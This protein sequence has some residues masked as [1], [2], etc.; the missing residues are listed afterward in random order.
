MKRVFY[1]LFCFILLCSCKTE[2]IGSDVPPNLR[3]VMKDGDILYF[4]DS[5][6][7]LVDTFVL[8]ISSYYTIYDNN[9]TIQIKYINKGDSARSI[10]S[11]QSAYGI[12]F[13]VN[14]FGIDGCRVDNPTNVVKNV[15]IN[16]VL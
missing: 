10:D 16:N 4:K 14:R 11:Y 7:N 5:V 3:P 15:T 6:N 9:E 12:G 1:P 2:P 13:F 8:R